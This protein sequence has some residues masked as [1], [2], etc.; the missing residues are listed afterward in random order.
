MIEY[1]TNC[2]TLLRQLHDPDAGD[3]DGQQGGRRPAVQLPE[4]GKHQCGDAHRESDRP[5]DRQGRPA[6]LPPCGRAAVFSGSLPAA[7]QQLVGRDPEDVRE[8]GKGA[9]VGAGDSR[10]P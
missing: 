9:D 8:R 1:I 4:H 3:A 6:E 7:A 10:F 5:E 2:I